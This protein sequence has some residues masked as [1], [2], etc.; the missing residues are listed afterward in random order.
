MYNIFF[1]VFFPWPFLPP[2]EMEKNSNSINHNN[3]QMIRDILKYILKGSR[4]YDLKPG[5]AKHP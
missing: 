1:W 3:N 5:G 4:G 2:P